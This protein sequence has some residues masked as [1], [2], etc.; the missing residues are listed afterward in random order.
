[1]TEKMKMTYEEAREIA[2]AVM[3]NYESDESEI[4]NSGCYNNG[5]WFSRRTMFYTIIAA[6]TG[7][8]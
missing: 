3:G 8:Y 4:S 7:D 1:M 5:E 6:L 2:F